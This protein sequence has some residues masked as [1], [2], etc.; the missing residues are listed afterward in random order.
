MAHTFNSS[1][2]MQMLADLWVQGPVGLQSE[3]QESQGHTD[4]PWF[5]EQNKTKEPEFCSRLMK[6][7]R[8]L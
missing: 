1:T 5:N 2:W 6:E 3:F 4:K 7:S 8:V